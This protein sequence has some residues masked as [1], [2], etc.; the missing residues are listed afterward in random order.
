[1]ADKITYT[2]ETL[3][4]LIREYKTEL[5]MCLTECD[6]QYHRGIVKTYE[7]MLSQMDD[8]VIGD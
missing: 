5:S 2:R 7:V 6:K 8:D 3:T 1:M 4:D